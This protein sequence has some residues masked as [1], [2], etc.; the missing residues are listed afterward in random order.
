MNPPGTLLSQSHMSNTATAPWVAALTRRW[1]S[2]P[3]KPKATQAVSS[4][5]PLAGGLGVQE[6]GSRSFFRWLSSRVYKGPI[7]LRKL[8]ASAAQ[9]PRSEDVASCQQ[10]GSACKECPPCEVWL[11]TLLASSTPIQIASSE[12]LS[13]VPLGISFGPVAACSWISTAPACAAKRS[14]LMQAASH[15]CRSRLSSIGMIV[16]CP[17]S[18]INALR[19]FCGLSVACSL[20][21]TAK[22]IRREYHIPQV[23][24]RNHISKYSGVCNGSSQTLDRRWHTR[25][26]C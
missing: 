6:Q 22:R 14:F 3:G 25:T 5:P 19:V 21:L 18:R 23:Y 10:L 16:F 8:W 11:L 1:V 24:L 26:C 13:A 12:E 7:E 20:Y 9:A 2:I 4:D 17:G 15:G